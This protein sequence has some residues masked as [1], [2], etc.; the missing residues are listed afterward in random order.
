[1]TFFDM[2]IIAAMI[3][4]FGIAAARLNDIKK[5]Q[6]AARW[7]FRRMGL[8]MTMVGTGG[9]VMAYI[10]LFAPHW[11]DVTSLLIFWGVA[12]TWITTPNQ[13]PLWKYISR[14]DPPPEA[15]LAQTTFK[16]RL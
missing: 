1:M 2:L 9:R 7:W 6:K 16:D 3:V 10:T 4:M 13:P 14:N 5:N 11:Y 8:L 12:L 15:V